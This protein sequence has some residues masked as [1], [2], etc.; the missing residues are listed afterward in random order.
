MIGLEIKNST[1]EMMISADFRHPH[2]LLRTSFGPPVFQTRT[3]EGYY[4]SEHEPISSWDVNDGRIIAFIGMPD[5]GRFYGMH[6]SR[7]CVLGLAPAGDLPIAYVFSSQVFPRGPCMGLQLCDPSNQLMYDSMLKPLHI[8]A[9]TS[10]A[11]S[12]P[13]QPQLLRGVIPS[14]PAYFLPSHYEEIGVKRTG[15]FITV[16]DWRG[17]WTLQ[18]DRLIKGDLFQVA[19]SYEDNTRTYSVQHGYSGAHQLMCIDAAIYD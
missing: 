5:D 17:L 4:Y 8:A 3:N 6:F 7:L 13:I 15:G 9:A 19:Q 12:S 14:R 16:Q 10:A 1:Q 11:V 2:L 18:P